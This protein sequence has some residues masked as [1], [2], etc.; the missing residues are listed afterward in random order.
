MSIAAAAASIPPLK[1]LQPDR[2]EP[3]VSTRAMQVLLAISALSCVTGQAGVAAVLC[4]RPWFQGG[5]GTSAQVT[6]SWPWPCV[7]SVGL[8]TANCCPAHVALLHRNFL[9]CALLGLGH[10]GVIFGVSLKT[11]AN[12]CSHFCSALLGCA[13]F[14]YC[15]AGLA[16]CSPLWRFWSQMKSRCSVS[17]PCL[18]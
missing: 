8:S 15:P 12:R 11:T 7:F 3:R 17:T 6:Q 2:P 13:L 1:E 16:P 5:T 18:C 4:T 14:A 10:P 9:A